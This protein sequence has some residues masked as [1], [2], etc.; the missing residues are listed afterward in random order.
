M[1]ILNSLLFLAVTATLCLAQTLS[2]RI[3][4]SIPSHIDESSGIEVLGRNRILSFN[5][6]GGEAEI[7]IFDTLGTDLGTFVIDGA[8]NIDWEDIT[9]DDEFIFIGDC[10]NNSNT[11][12][13]LCIYKTNI[14]DSLCSANLS[15]SSIDYYYPDQTAFPP[16]DSEK[17]FDCEALVS[18]G[19]S[20]FLFTKNYSSP[21]TGYTKRYAIPK[22]P[23]SFSA[24]LVDSYYTGVP[25]AS[26]GQL[27]AADISPSGDKLVLLA[28]RY[29][30]IFRD[31]SGSDFFLCDTF[32]FT[33]PTLSQ[34]EAVCFVSDSELYLTD[35]LVWFGG[36]PYGG[37]LYY[38]NLNEALGVSANPKKPIDIGITAYPNP[39]NSSV[40]IA[41]DAPVGAG[42]AN[43]YLMGEETLHPKI[44]IFDL[45]GRCVA[46]LFS[47][48]SFCTSDSL[49]KG[50]SEY[51]SNSV[52]IPRGS[53]EIIWA[54]GKAIG[55]GI[56]LV[57]LQFYN[58][59][60]ATKM[61][62]YIK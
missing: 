3:I 38:A 44:D 4:C 61:V 25:I 62:V 13:D 26:G 1:R 52:E 57:H 20:L 9:R 30:W 14:P 48:Y 53:W 2:M 19:D 46:E 45:N 43:P 12:T 51:D 8:T 33:L 50:I 18:H 31:F 29:L 35:E 47:P 41:I 24:T 23:G 21:F 59:S 7:F 27:T 22:T 10:G 37:N 5:D 17:N 49:V 54:P 15:C 55:S 16:P 40:R 58:G 36:T 34:I 42:S 60:T 32:A 6:S 28:Y 39:F 56:Y 11:R